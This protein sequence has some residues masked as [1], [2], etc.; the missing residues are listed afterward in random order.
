[1]F[2]MTSVLVVDDEFGDCRCWGYLPDIK[3]AMQEIHHENEEHEGELFFD[4]EFNYLVIEEINEGLMAGCKREWW[5]KFTNSNEWVA[6]EKPVGIEK[7]INF[8]IG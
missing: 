1:M 6:C 5:Y 7:V 4:R 3:S 8:G 2:F